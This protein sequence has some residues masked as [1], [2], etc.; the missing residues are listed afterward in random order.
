MSRN[1]VMASTNT[2]V[3]DDYSLSR[4]PEDGKNP[5]WKVVMVRLGAISCLPI[6]MV[7][8]QI[9]YGLTF[10]Q[11][12][13]AVFVGSILLQVVG[14]AVGTIAAKEGLSTSLLTRW[15]GFGKFGSSLIGLIIA[16]TCFGWFGIQN[17]VFAEGLMVASGMFNLQVWSVIAGIVITLIVVFGF[18]FMSYTANIFLPLFAIGVFYAF[19]KMLGG[20]NIGVLMTEP[21]PGA[22]LTMGAAI[23]V[24]AGGFILGAVITP[25]MTRFLKSGREVFI[26]VLISTFVGE[27][28][29]YT[30]GSLMAHAQNTADVAAI[31]YGLSGALGLLLVVSSTIKINDVNLYVASLGITNFF[32]LTFKRQFN[33]GLVT[34]FLGVIGT[35][36][37]VAGILNHFV[38]FLTILGV[39]IPPIA[40]I[41]VVDYFILKRSRAELD[42]SRE[43]GALP[44]SVEIWNPISIITWVLS[45]LFGYLVTSIGIPAINSLVASAILYYVLMKIFDKKLKNAAA[46]HG[47]KEEMGDRKYASQS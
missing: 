36:L 7:G 38:T 33:R 22:A 11:G 32:A 19:Y 21:A 43:K 18:R 37:S 30:L 5:L 41:A 23:T 27:L 35:I 13:F 1:D 8:A 26:A 31:M 34:L 25:D 44:E 16:I 20:H 12:F 15:T 10:W 42:E 2:K 46:V 29:F 28:V 4:V 14:W 40:G 6:L 3:V 17:S 9:G 45:S 24:V 47:S 39:T